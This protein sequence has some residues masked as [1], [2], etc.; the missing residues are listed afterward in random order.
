MKEYKNVVDW[1][2]TYDGQHLEPEFLP[3]AVPLLL[4]NGAFGIGYGLRTEIPSHNLNEVID[5]TI[6]L[7]H[8]PDAR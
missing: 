8:N 3:V 4:I 7:M 1:I 2:P 6:K 5:A